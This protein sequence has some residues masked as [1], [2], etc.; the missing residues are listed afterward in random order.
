LGGLLVI[1]LLQHTIDTLSLSVIVTL[2]VFSVMIIWFQK[3]SKGATL[4][5]DMTNSAPS[6]RVLA[7]VVVGFALAG[8]VGYSLPRGEVASDPLA[9]IGALF[10]AYGLIWLPA[11]SIVLGARA[12]T[13]QARAMN[14]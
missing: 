3:R 9:L 1:H 10:T 13:R 7:V 6:T 12:F 14:L 5:D 2:T 8:A 4:L 11:V